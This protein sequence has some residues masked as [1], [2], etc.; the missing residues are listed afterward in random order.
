VNKYFDNKIFL[1]DWSEEDKGK[2]VDIAKILLK[3]VFIFF[4]GIND[5]NIINYVTDLE[6]NYE[7]DFWHLVCVTIYKD[8][9]TEKILEILRMK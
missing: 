8:I 4:N 6:F 2:Y 5:N 1:K 7:E 3:K 9:S